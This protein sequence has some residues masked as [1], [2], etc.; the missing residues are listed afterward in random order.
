M[1]HSI[2]AR[3]MRIYILSLDGP[4]CIHVLA[5]GDF[6]DEFD[7]VI[8]YLGTRSQVATFLFFAQTIQKDMMTQ[9]ANSC[10]K[11]TLVRQAMKDQAVVP[12]ASRCPV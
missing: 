7:D 5:R 11:P 12:D 9:C 2:A 8:E 6:L 10:M 1:R 4:L 3:D